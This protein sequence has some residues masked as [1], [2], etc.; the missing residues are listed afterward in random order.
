MFSSALRNASM[1]GGL[2]AGE[3]DLEVE[4]E[5]AH[6]GLVELDVRRVGAE[7]LA[8]AAGLRRGEV[9]GVL[10][11]VLVVEDVGVLLGE[12]R[13]DVPADDA[14]VALRAHVH[15]G[16]VALALEE[17]LLQVGVA[18]VLDD[19]VDLAGA[20]ALPGD[21]LLEVLVLDRAAQLVLRDRADDVGAGLVAHPRVDGHVEVAALAAP[22]PR[23]AT[24]W[25]R[26]PRRST[27]R[28]RRRT[29]PA[30]RAVAR[31]AR[32]PARLSAQFSSCCSS[33]PGG[34]L[35]NLGGLAG[36]ARWAAGCGT[37]AAAPVRRHVVRRR[38]R[39]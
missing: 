33:S 22:T 35:E 11:E 18:P 39:A 26:S 31:A 7:E 24:R 23:P 5:V 29:A 2:R 4:V 6:D 37:P 10:V 34:V 17:L 25:P 28:R 15:R 16:A 9:R 19:D 14:D 38:P 8:L 3:D 21:V 36:A 20:E 1:L 12:P 30:W 32:R 13:R 27:P